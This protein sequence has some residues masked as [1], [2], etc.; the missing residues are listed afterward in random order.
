M[1]LVTS[2]YTTIIET[3]AKY[4]EYLRDKD[5]VTTDIVLEEAYAGVLIKEDIKEN[6]TNPDEV[7]KIV[8]DANLSTVLSYPLTNY[9]GNISKTTITSSIQLFQGADNTPVTF[10][11][12]IL[13]INARHG[14]VSMFEFNNGDQI[15]L[16]IPE[17]SIEIDDLY[18]VSLKVVDIFPS[19]VELKISAKVLIQ[20][21]LKVGVETIP[22]KVAYIGSRG[23]DT[24]YFKTPADEVSER[25]DFWCIFGKRGM[26]AKLAAQSGR[27]VELTMGDELLN[28]GGFVENDTLSSV[29]VLGK[30]IDLSPY[31]LS[32]EPGR[33]YDF[34]SYSGTYNAYAVQKDP[35]TM[36][37]L[38]DVIPFSPIL[39]KA[40]RGL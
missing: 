29:S 21:E 34:E 22:D 9:E 16:I 1:N 30:S 33:G 20:N 10:K 17:S 39:E 25:G 18:I 27:T 24:R 14:D 11:A 13:K 23:P 35:N 7:A 4:L 6:I 32:Y 40:I 31:M 37:I 26:V 19:E 38:K 3:I 28:I 12:R 36:V 5:V 2:S 8:E 15:S